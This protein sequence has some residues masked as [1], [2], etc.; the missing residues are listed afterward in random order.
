MVKYR[1]D[2][3]SVPWRLSAL[4]RRTSVW[5]RN[6]LRPTRLRKI[7]L[8]KLDRKTDRL[9]VDRIDEKTFHGR[10]QDSGCPR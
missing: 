4:Q 7:G 6:P 10:L 2:V 3:G 1:S 5:P 8:S 9:K